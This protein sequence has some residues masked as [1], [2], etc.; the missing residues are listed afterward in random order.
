MLDF[1]F[2]RNLV[3]LLNILSG[4]GNVC[5]GRLKFLHRLFEVMLGLR[6]RYNFT[7]LSRFTGYTDKTIRK[8]YDK[9]LDFLGLNLGIL[10][11][12][13]VQEGLLAFDASFLKKS[14]KQT[15]GLDWFYSSDKGMGWKGLEISTLALVDFKRK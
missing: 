7:H 9:G 12:I 3:S 4:L 1:P 6:G 5:N 13:G 2:E 11:C 15:W 14:G 10:K 8:H